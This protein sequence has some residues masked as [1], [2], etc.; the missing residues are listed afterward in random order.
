[1]L[2]RLNGT[3]I[4]HPETISVPGELNLSS[5]AS[6][7]LCTVLRIQMG[8]PLVVFSGDGMDYHGKLI[9]SHKKQARV[10]ISSAVKNYSESSLSVHLIQALCKGEKMDFIL[11]KSVELGVTEISPVISERSQGHKGLKE[12]EFLTKKTEHYQR[13]VISAC[14][15]S[16]R[17]VIPLVHPI[18]N[19]ENYFR[20]TSKNA[21]KGRWILAP[22]PENSPLSIK[23]LTSPSSTVE[24]IVGPEGGLSSKEIENAIALDYLPLSLGPRILRTETAALAFIAGLQSRFGDF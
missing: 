15:Q 17:S 1:M 2:S 8:E 22:S 10:F 12:A 11:Q 23:T 4:F 6:H 19:L 24:F 16:G 7:H 18:Q 3:R 9:F 20:Q 5:E 14:E 21:L 13:V